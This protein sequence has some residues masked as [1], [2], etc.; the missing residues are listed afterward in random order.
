MSSG[1]QSS[2]TNARFSAGRDH[3]SRDESIDADVGNVVK[4]AV[5]DGMCKNT[6]SP[7]NTVNIVNLVR[8]I[9]NVKIVALNL[10]AV[11]KDS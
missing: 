1:T 7:T 4:A 8:L 5:D 2:L 9:Q 3:G 6:R 10:W 11:Y